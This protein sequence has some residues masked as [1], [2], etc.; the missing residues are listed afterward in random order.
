[1]LKGLARSGGLRAHVLTDGVIRVGDAIED[2]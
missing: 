1:M 2:L